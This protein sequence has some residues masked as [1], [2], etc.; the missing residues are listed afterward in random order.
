MPP[1]LPSLPPVTPPLGQ[2]ATVE[3]E[4]AYVARLR[5]EYDQLHERHNRLLALDLQH[6]SEMWLEVYAA[7]RSD[8]LH[9]MRDVLVERQRLITRW[10]IYV[11]Q[12]GNGPQ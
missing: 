5:E 9:R 8:I 10:L 7:R 6:R 11:R 4:S 1:I 2:D 12:G 3:E